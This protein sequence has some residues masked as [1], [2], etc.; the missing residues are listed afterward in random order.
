MCQSG[1]SWR[2]PDLHAAVRCISLCGAARPRTRRH[3][4]AAW[5]PARAYCLARMPLVCS[6]LHTYNGGMTQSRS[7]WYWMICRRGARGQAQRRGRAGF[8]SLG[9]GCGGDEP[10]ED[11][12][13]KLIPGR[14]CGGDAPRKSM[15]HC[16]PLAR[17]SVSAKE[18]RRGFL[19]SRVRG[20]RAR[21]EPHT[22]QCFLLTAH[23]LLPTGVESI[24]GHPRVNR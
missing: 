13:A 11:P 6:E 8:G 10:R 12:Q 21:Q 4:R 24:Y 18:N 5:K 15:T 1:C 2:R 23:Q 22:R 7:S 9:R 17:A 14:R 3:L 19:W 20:R 16:P